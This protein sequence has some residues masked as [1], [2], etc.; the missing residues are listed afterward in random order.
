[1]GRLAASVV[2]AGC[3]ASAC[4]QAQV[5]SPPDPEFTRGSQAAPTIITVAPGGTEGDLILPSDIEADVET[6]DGSF[7]V[8]RMVLVD[9]AGA[10]VP[11]PARWAAFD[12]ALVR[13]LGANQA[14]GVAVMID[15]QL[16][17]H[18]AHGDR[19]AGG[20][21]VEAGDRFR[22]A[23]ISKT[24]TAIVTMQLIEDGVLSLDEPIGSI[25]ADH[26]GVAA[27]DGDAV[28]ATVRDLLSHTAGFPKHEG[29]FFGSGSASCSDAATQGIVANVSSGTGYRYSNMGYCVLG[30]LIEAVTGKTYERVVDERLLGPLGI[31]GMRFTGT[32]ELGPDEVSHA[33]TPGR[34]Y[35]EALGAAGS[36][37]ATPADLVAILNAIDHDTAG[38]K[39]VSAET[40][41]S[42]RF[43]ADTGQQPGG[44][45]LGLINYESDAWGHTG[46]IENTHA[47]V[48][49]QTD[50]VTWA[51]TVAG[52]YPSSSGQLRYLIR[53]AMVEAFG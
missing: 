13:R 16:V 26:L 35:M 15:G 11:D 6:L 23:S 45:G 52:G 39:A 37:N 20:E 40:A 9:D 42:M 24:I 12:D 25:V 28:S 22:V 18:A 44:Y 48:L 14:F 53:S 43:R 10:A 8:G 38:W 27:P 32:H 30:V 19:V 47:M 7:D 4:G 34:N 46:T 41:R 29:T 33:V 36:W 17:H 50:G 21:S 31:D 5:A 49:R 3:L 2:T 1:M 51:I